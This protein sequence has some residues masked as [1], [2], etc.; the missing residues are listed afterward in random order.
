[1]TQRCAYIAIRTSKRRK[2]QASISGV[3]HFGV[4][5]QGQQAYPYLHSTSLLI[6]STSPSRHSSHHLSLTSLSHTL[7]CTPHTH[8][9]GGGETEEEEERKKKRKRERERGNRGGGT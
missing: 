4:K 2:T 7:T 9:A 8:K 3:L 1:M 5:T 6:I